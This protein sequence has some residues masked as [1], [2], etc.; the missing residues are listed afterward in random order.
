ML[1]DEL[2]QHSAAVSTSVP[3]SKFLPGVLAF[4]SLNEGLEHVSQNK[5]FPPQIGSMF[6][7]SEK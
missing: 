5:L 3:A 7:P 4:F 2:E 6:Y 1:V